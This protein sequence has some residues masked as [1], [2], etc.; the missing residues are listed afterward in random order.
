MRATTRRLER[1][2]DLV[3]F[4]GSDGCLFLRDGV[5]LAGR[6]V[7]ARVARAEV[8]GALA[9]IDVA[10]GDAHG[11]V[12]FGALPFLPGAGGELLVPA[13]VVRRDPDGSSWLTTIDGVDVDL[14]PAPPP[15]AAGGGYTLRPGFDP[16]AF[17]AAVCRGRDLVRGGQLTKVVVARDVLVE[18]EHPIDVHAVLTRLRASF[19][20]SHLFAV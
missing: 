16:A 3:A 15:P 14:T 4:A 7:A 20:S 19:G 1:P 18:A 5:G 8:G 9:G 13:A 17:Q 6:G 2:V 10:D 12:A 11:P